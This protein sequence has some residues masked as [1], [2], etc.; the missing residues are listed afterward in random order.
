[1]NKKKRTLYLSLLILIAAGAFLFFNSLKPQGK[2]VAVCVNESCSYYDLASDQTVAIGKSNV[3]IIEN[4]LA[5]MDAASCPDQ[6]CVKTGKIS[7]LNQ[8]IICLPNRVVVEI[9]E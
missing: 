4:G 3:L 5:Y 1:M 6:I 9:V 7:L 2:R 8:T